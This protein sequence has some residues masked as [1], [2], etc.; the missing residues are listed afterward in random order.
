[1]KPALTWLESLL[2]Y[3]HAAATLYMTGIIWLVQ[4]A[5]YPL[6]PRIDRDQF[7]RYEHEYTR[8][9]GWVVGPPMLI[10][11]LTAL[12]LLYLHGG[13]LIWSALALLAVVWFSTIFWQIPQHSRL[14]RGFDAATHQALVRTNWIRTVAW[15]ARSVLALAIL[16]RWSHG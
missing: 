15:S 9:M 6:F 1:M 4:I 10:E 14:E 16:A 8:R 5:H 13:W 12:A 7:V 3:L 11:L 2:P